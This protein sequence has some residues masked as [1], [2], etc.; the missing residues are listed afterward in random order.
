MGQLI[1]SCRHSLVDSSTPTI[2]ADQR[3]CPKHTIYTFIIYSQIRTTFILWN[4][5]NTQNDA[6]F[7]SFKKPKYYSNC[8]L[9]GQHILLGISPHISWIR[10]EIT[11]HFVGSLYSPSWR[12]VVGFYLSSKL[13]LVRIAVVVIFDGVIVVVVAVGNF[14]NTLSWTI[15]WLFIFVDSCLERFIGVVICAYFGRPLGLKKEKFGAK[16]LTL[17]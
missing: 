2:P 6:G 14:V 8:V 7:G 11:L 1:K 17:I 4:D 15:S 13:V 12:V 9:L 16:Q 3:S 10:P 5:R